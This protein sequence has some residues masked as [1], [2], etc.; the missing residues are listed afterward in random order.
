MPAV[1]CYYL[2]NDKHI[3][4]ERERERE[5][6]S[7]CV[8]VCETKLH[9]HTS[10]LVHNILCKSIQT[11]LSFVVKGL[12]FNTINPYRGGIWRKKPFDL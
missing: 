10:H 3:E 11:I 8:C 6:E 12:S 2:Y 7:V 4:T 1:K 5:R 9:I